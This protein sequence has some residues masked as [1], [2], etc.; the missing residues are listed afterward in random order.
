MPTTFF[1]KFGFDI[2]YKIKKILKVLK[3]EVFNF[4]HLGD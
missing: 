3:L 4:M 1:L 2:I